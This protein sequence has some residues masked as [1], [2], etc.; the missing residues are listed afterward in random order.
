MKWI[1]MLVK[2]CTSIKLT[3]P[4]INAASET[5]G[6]LHTPWTPHLKRRYNYDIPVYHPWYHEMVYFT[7]VEYLRQQCALHITIV[8]FRLL[9]VQN[10]WPPTVRLAALPKLYI[11]SMKKA[12]KTDHWSLICMLCVYCWNFL[13]YHWSKLGCTQQASVESDNLENDD[14]LTLLVHETKVTQAHVSGVTPPLLRYIV[15]NSGSW[16]AGKL[17]SCL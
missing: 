4:L 9:R 7:W 14:W 17:L 8:K 6:G 13:H 3:H 11:D 2:S 10:T 5:P 16:A 12:K 15:T 1:I